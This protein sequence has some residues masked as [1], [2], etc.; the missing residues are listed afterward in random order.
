MAT[1]SSVLAWRIPG[2]GEPGGLPSMGSH[3][4]R[5]NW[6]DLAVAA[7]GDGR[8]TQGGGPNSLSTGWQIRWNCLPT[9]TFLALLPDNFMSSGPESASSLDAP[10]FTCWS[11][12]VW[13]FNCLCFL[14]QRCWALGSLGETRKRALY[15]VSFD[16]HNKGPKLTYTYTVLDNLQSPRE[17]QFIPQDPAP[18]FTHLQLSQ[19]ELILPSTLCR[20]SIRPLITL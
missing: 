9:S 8:I 6:S 15:E 10:Q 17:L 20:V 14:S 5:H 4:V 2:T 16:G 1:H 3:R 18:I 11:T 7:H 12:D 19:A 13:L